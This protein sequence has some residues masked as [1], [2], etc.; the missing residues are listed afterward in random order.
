M[1]SVWSIPATPAREKQFGKHPTQKP[2]ALLTRLILAT[3]SKD[4]MVLDPFLGSGTT[5]V[6]AL[7]LGRRFVGVD[8]D[9]AFVDL[10]EKRIHSIEVD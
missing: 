7:E 3:T 10:A 4:D 1:R 9:E 2:V 8:R 6:V 5:G